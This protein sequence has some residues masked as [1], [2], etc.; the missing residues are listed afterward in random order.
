[1]NVSS[2]EG[3][4]RNTIGAEGVKPL[5]KVLLHNKYL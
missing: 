2:P 4:N 5:K 3:L 1:V